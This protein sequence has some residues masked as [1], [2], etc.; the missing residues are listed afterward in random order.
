MKW[1]LLLVAL[2][3]AAGTLSGTAQLSP[4][5][6][7][8][9]LLRSA[10][11]QA[12][13]KIKNRASQETRKALDKTEQAVDN[14]AS[15][16]GGSSAAADTPSEAAAGKTD[17]KLD[18]KTVYVS[19]ARGSAR[20]TGTKDSPYRDLQKAVDEAPD[21]AVICV[22]EGNYLGRL[23]AGYVEVKNK[24]LKLMGGYSDDFS[25]R[26]PLKYITKIQPTKA[27]NGTN[28][29]KGL[30]TL[31]VKG[32]RNEVLLVD[33]F[34]FDLGEQNIYHPADPKDPRNGCCEGCETGRITP[35]GESNGLAHQLMHG[36]VEGK[37]IVRNCLFANGGYYGIQMT[38]FGG[39]WEIYNNVFV[40]NVF[41]SCAIGGAGTG[42]G[43]PII[44]SVDFHHNTVL[45]SWCRTKVMEDMG[46]GF[47]YMTGIH[48]NVYNNIFG[49][50]NL[51]AL[52]RTYIDSDKAKEAERKTS[53]YNNMFFMNKSDIVLPSPG[54]GKWTMVKAAR[55]DEVEQLQ[56]YEGNFE[57]PS[58]SNIMKVIDPAYL[59][60]FASLEVVSS[61]S[62]DPNSAANQYRQAHGMNMQGTE[63]VRVT[64][65][66]N[67]YNVEKALAVFGAETT[68]GAQKIKD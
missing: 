30:L 65:Y 37:L 49:C 10:G 60:G 29:S 12:E 15:N 9:D 66:G 44:A 40:A 59:K 64:M 53:A 35:G 58:G 22:A 57:A 1:K 45:F 63:I 56:K 52:D 21:G 36:Y 13:Q 43:K 23:D 27:Q 50:S 31:D 55:F 38:N 17:V 41:A 51:G 54:G 46:Y 2:L 61:S 4:G 11:K 24:Y 39:H 14:A 34:V 47:R 16:V 25:Q 8:K 42:Q 67:R 28:G 48:A 68:Y 32:K 19:A 33:G 62:F 18:G 26:N 7:G 20:A 5:K 6:L 3:V